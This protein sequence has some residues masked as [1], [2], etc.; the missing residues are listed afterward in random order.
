MYR[1]RSEEIF[2]FLKTTILF[3]KILF[4]VVVVILMVCV[5]TDL[6]QE[7]EGT[8]GLQVALGLFESRS[9][10]GRFLHK[11][12]LFFCCS[13]PLNLVFYHVASCNSDH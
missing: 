9:D 8:C 6:L 2:L 13:I 10:S 11:A 12:C 3:L 7:E 1:F 5:A 4:F